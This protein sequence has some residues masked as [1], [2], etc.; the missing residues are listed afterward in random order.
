MAS[1]HIRLQSHIH[2]FGRVAF[3]SNHMCMLASQHP[4]LEVLPPPPPLGGETSCS[5]Y[6][7]HAM[8]AL[9]KKI[10]KLI[11]HQIYVYSSNLEVLSEDE[12]IIVHA[13][14]LLVVDLKQRNIAGWC[15]TQGKQKV[16]CPVFSC[17]LVFLFCFVF[18]LASARNMMN[19][20][21]V[22]NWC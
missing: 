2:T 12:L 4:P 11:L 7:R 6:A 18:I 16:L 14:K 3:D 10:R 21:R 1:I 13:Y 5:L 20:A 22:K 17:G 15:S 8:H 9:G 19:G